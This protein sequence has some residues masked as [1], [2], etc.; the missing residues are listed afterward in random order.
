[1]NLDPLK[2]SSD[3]QIWE[4]LEAAQLKTVINGLEKKLGQY[5]RGKVNIIAMK[6]NIAAM[7]VNVIAVKVN[8]IAVKVN[9]L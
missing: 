8:V 1:M 5:V 7:K 9:I 3:V 2:S 4:A 6:V